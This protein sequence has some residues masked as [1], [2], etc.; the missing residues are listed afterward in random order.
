MFDFIAIQYI[1]MKT[2]ITL[3]FLFVATTSFSQSIDK[4]NERYGF[5]DAILESDIKTFKGMQ[6]LESDG[7]FKYYTRPTDKLYIG[8]NKLETIIYSFQN[9]KL[10]AITFATKGSSNSKG[11]LNV[12]TDQY[13]KGHQDNPLIENYTWQ[14]SRVRMTY[15]ENSITNNAQIMI[16]SMYMANEYRK[17][18]EESAKRAADDL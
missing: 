3:F 2:L 7:L 4:L 17:Y 11:V 16:M 14:S 1:L 15:T 10:N 12:L 13:G 6:L 18:K 8:D 9:G 5:R